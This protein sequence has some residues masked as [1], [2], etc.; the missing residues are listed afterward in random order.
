M[1]HVDTCLA[2]VLRQTFSDFELIFVDNK[3]TDG[4]L[5]H[6]RQNF[7]GVVFVANE[8]NVGYAG[9]INSGLAVAKGHYIAPLNIDTDLSPGWLGHLV[10][11]MEEH[12]QAGAVTPRIMLFDDRQTVNTMGLNI[13]VSGLAFCRGLGRK[14]DGSVKTKKV[15]GISGCSYLIRRELLEKM[16]GAPQECFMASDDVVVSW[17]LNLMGWDMYCIPASVVYHKYNLKMTADKFFMLERNRHRLLLYSLKWP[18]LVACLP[19]LGLTE[20]L[21]MGYCVR[22]GGPYLRAKWRAVSSLAHDRP[23][24]KERRQQVQKLRQVSDC[25]MLRRL[26]LNLDWGQLF[27]IS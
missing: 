13:H 20:L 17:L 7:P 2:S 6:T 22:K 8:E 3:S 15:S 16:G 11:F 23:F 10:D 24:I 12:P 25:A 4:S 26:K 18:T 21:V 27:Q 5:E 19:V 1:S 9:G 14:D